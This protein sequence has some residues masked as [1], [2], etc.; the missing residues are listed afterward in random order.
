VSTGYR[1]G[2]QVDVTA[3]LR[4]GDRVVVDGGIFVQFMQNQ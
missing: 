1:A 4:V 3:G 2:D